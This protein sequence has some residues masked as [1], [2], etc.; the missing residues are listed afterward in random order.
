MWKWLLKILEL[1]APKSKS[2][3]L[4]D[5]PVA[6]PETNKQVIWPAAEVLDGFTHGYETENEMRDNGV[7]AAIAAGFD[8]IAVEWR[9]DWNPEVSIHLLNY[10]SNVDKGKFLP[11]SW[12]FRARDAG[13]KRWV[14]IVK[15]TDMELFADRFKAYAPSTLQCVVSDKKL[16]AKLTA[17]LGLDANGVKVSE[18]RFR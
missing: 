11:S 5:A 13:I 16:M 2:A 1:F 12:F 9:T 17:L 4:P 8:T 3:A 7:R 10:E 18:A 15:T 14:V 6:P